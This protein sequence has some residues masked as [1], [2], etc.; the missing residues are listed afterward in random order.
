MPGGR[1]FGDSKEDN[2]KILHRDIVNNLFELALSI[3]IVDKYQQLS[4][5]ATI[6][7]QNYIKR[8]DT[9]MQASR[10]QDLQ[11]DVYK[12]PFMVFNDDGQITPMF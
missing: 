9:E 2:A 4:T 11:W 3:S 10:L 8:S 5:Q 12:Y 7:S 6:L 1:I